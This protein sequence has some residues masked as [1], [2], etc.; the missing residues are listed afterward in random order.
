[1]D[2]DFI[3]GH[4][5]FHFWNEHL[6]KTHKIFTVLREPT[7]RAISHYF[8]RNR[9]QNP[10]S[11]TIRDFNSNYLQNRDFANPVCKGIISRKLAYTS[12]LDNLSNQNLYERALEILLRDFAFIGLLEDI[13]NWA[14]RLIGSMGGPSIHIK[15]IKKDNNPAKKEMLELHKNDLKELN[16]ADYNLYA[17]ISK[18]K[19]KFLNY[20]PKTT[21]GSNSLIASVT[22]PTGKDFIVN[23]QS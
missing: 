9:N 2:A 14:G 18:N 20:L 13:D 22:C 21:S 12:K 17:E 5:S 11:L 16:L 7:S 15:K 23:Q 6:R 4:S 3:Y 8:W 10:E 1:M 19:S